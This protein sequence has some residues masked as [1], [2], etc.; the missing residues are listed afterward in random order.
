MPGAQDATIN[1]IEWGVNNLRA[2][3]VWSS[4]GVRGAGVV[5]ANIDTGVQWTHPALKPHYH[6]RGDRGCDG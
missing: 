3:Q 6:R 2:P 1:T 4:Y 5:V